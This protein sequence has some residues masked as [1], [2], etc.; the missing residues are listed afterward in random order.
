MEKNNPARK[1]C[2]TTKLIVNQ[3]CKRVL[4]LLLNHPTGKHL[5]S[6]FDNNLIETR[7]MIS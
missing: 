7:Y 6:G 1:Y 4:V 2:L 5:A 3:P